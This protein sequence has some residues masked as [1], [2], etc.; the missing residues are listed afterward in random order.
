NRYYGWYLQPGKIDE[1]CQSLSEEIDNLYE[2]YHKPILLSEFGADTIPGW[3][4]QPPEMFSEEFQAEFLK[5]YIAIC[6]SKPYVIGEHV[7]NL[8]DFK[9]SQGITRMGGINYK[10]V[11]TRDRRPKMAAHVVKQLWKKD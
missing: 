4:S 10:G 6:R 3:H 11:F 8:C 1:A 5:K 9:T 7:W 2:R